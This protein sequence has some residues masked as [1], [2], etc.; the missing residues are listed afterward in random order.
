MKKEVG[1]GSPLLVFLSGVCGGR[2]LGGCNG[3]LAILLEELLDLERY[4]A[5]ACACCLV[6]CLYLSLRI[7]AECLETCCDLINESFHCLL[8]SEI[9]MNN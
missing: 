9:W 4:L 6:T 7:L 1:G 3:V 2:L 8:I 5:G